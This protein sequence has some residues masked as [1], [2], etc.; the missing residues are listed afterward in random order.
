MEATLGSGMKAARCHGPQDAEF[1]HAISVQFYVR[2]AG[3]VAVQ[4]HDE[5]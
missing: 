4:G 1:G 5:R 3:C 2:H